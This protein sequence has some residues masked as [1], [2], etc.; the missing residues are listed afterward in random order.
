MILFV[1]R[2]G[3]LHVRFLNKV[4]KRGKKE[5]KKRIGEGVRLTNKKLRHRQMKT[6][7]ILLLKIMH[8]SAY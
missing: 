2:D 5:E 7:Y 3:T 1:K 4:R 8:N 6:D